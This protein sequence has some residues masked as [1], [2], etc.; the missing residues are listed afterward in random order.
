MAI[1]VV[2][3]STFIICMTILCLTV[4]DGGNSG[5]QS[6]LIYKQNRRREEQFEGLT[7]EEI[8][9]IA[10]RSKEI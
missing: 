3:C 2:I 8:D 5:I 1:T 9:T 7:R 6:Y 4:S 10:Y